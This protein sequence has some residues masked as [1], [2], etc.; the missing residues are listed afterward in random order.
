MEMTSKLQKLLPYDW[1]IVNELDRDINADEYAVCIS[2]IAFLNG[3]IVNKDKLYL[4]KAYFNISKDAKLDL[5][6][7]GGFRES[8]FITIYINKSYSMQKK[9]YKYASE[10]KKQINKLQGVN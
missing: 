7:F 2:F 4:P 3:S 8:Q 5:V 1:R 10:C 9:L 6:D